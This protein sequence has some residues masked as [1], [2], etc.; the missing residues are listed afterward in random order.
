MKKS[1]AKKHKGF[2]FIAVA[3][4]LISAITAGIVFYPKDNEEDDV[5]W[6]EYEVQQ[7]DIV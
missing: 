3:V 6:R 4:L 5:I 2:I 7:G 1:N